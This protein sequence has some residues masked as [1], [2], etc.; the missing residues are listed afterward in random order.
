VLGFVGFYEVHN[1]DG[2]KCYQSGKATNYVDNE[3][4]LESASFLTSC[5]GYLFDSNPQ[6]QGQVQEY[7]M[8]GTSIGQIFQMQIT[9]NNSVNQ[10]NDKV[11]VPKGDKRISALASNPMTG[12]ICAGTS[13]GSILFLTIDE[14][15]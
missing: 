15:E 12:T 1:E 11:Y 13:N 9:Q 5:V 14:A 6:N 8:M 2:T 7:L 4:S 3:K 10:N